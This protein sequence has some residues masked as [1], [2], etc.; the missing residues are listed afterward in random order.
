[1]DISLSNRNK[2]IRYSTVFFIAFFTTLVMLMPF[3]IY[4]KGFFLY[5]GDYNS[6]QIPFTMFISRWFHSGLDSYSFGIDLGGSFVNSYSFY[7]LGS[8]FAMVL[9]LFPEQLVPYL[10][11]FMLC[12]KFATA[13][14]TGYLYLKRYL[15]VSRYAV[16]AA[17]L[18]SFSGFSIY[19]IFFNHFVDAVALFP[20]M[21]YSL[22][23]FFYKGRRG[24]F[25]I[26]V[27]LNLISN[28]FFF[29][30]QVVFIVIYF[31]A[32]LV[33]GEYT[34]TLKRFSFIAFETVLG[35][36]MGL[37]LA[38]P[39]F[40]NLLENPR[41]ISY[42][43]G[44]NLLLHGTSQ[45]YAAIISS[46]FLPPDP[47]YLPNLFTDGVIK[48]TSM[49]AYLPIFSVAGVVAYFRKKGSSSIKIVLV[50]C[51][52][53]ALVPIL[54][55]A[56]Y[57]FNSS[58]YARWFYMPLL[59]MALATGKAIEGNTGKFASSIFIVGGITLAYSFFGLVPNKVDGE[60]EIGLASNA[61]VF[62]LT[63]FTA[64]IGLTIGFFWVV[65][66]KRRSL[67]SPILIAFI[68]LFSIIYGIIHLAT[69]KIPQLDNDSDYKSQN[70]DTM[71]LNMLSEDDEFYRTDGYGTHD[72]NSIFLD[73][74][75]IQFFNSVVT[76]SI[77]EFYPSVGVKRDVSSKP[78][79][80]NYA[81]RSLLS[82]KYLLVP[83]S[84]EDDFLSNEQ[85]HG[86][87]HYQTIDQ[88]SI[89]KNDLYLP[90]GFVFD[91]Y[92]TE[93]V[94]N[95]T[96]ESSRSNLLL[97]GVVLTNDQITDY[98]D[99]LAE[100]D[101]L[102]ASK[103]TYDDMV[104][105]VGN[106]QTAYNFTDTGS[107]F[108]ADVSLSDDAMVM[109]SVPY[110]VG[111]KAYVD[112]EATAI[113]NVNS[114]LMAIAVPSGQHSISFVYE[115]PYLKLSAILCFIGIIVYIIYLFT[116]RYIFSRDVM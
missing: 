79:W 17:L 37:L 84:E 66:F 104:N 110:D 78:E 43:Y 113:E 39:A 109:F 16:P 69:G 9:M 36:M 34:L 93:D 13:A 7:T 90:M 99:I 5:C 74:N 40:M 2:S 58:Y 30:G 3:L 27:A 96:V 52:I 57:T 85:L 44:F 56:F 108:T 54:N 73:L 98:N 116:V 76:P 81:L 112:G 12:I 103:L 106:M 32:K 42:S 61:P 50:I 8:P 114:G 14:T 11:P 62:W 94:F 71:S 46:L 18:Y 35:L 68:S 70:Y 29:T 63:V 60:T 87:K 51:L 20:L 22:D 26:T 75:G 77:L 48:W 1:M 64:I 100:L 47:P 88:Y 31:F 38:L 4:D 92:I 102:Q 55:S 80:S 72:N 45:Q 107:G 53:M 15:K 28:Y 86:F 115:T 111:F 101:P 49:S 65:K 91:S 41:S 59:L 83:I 24:L 25:A 33:T 10:M 21:L 6:Q 105:D 97:K 95:E 89:Y 19:N 82:V 67:D 23:E